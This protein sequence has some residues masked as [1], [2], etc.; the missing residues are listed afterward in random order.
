M[1][2]LDHP[3]S[4]LKKLREDFDEM[5]RIGDATH[6]RPGVRGRR[7]ARGQCGTRGRQREK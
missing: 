4:K 2:A 3:V 5:E 7:G 1:G 6:G